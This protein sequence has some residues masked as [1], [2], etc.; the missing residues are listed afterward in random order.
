MMGGGI[1][2]IALG[3]QGPHPQSTLER[4][5][6][7]GPCPWSVARSNSL[8]PSASDGGLGVPTSPSPSAG[9]LGP[10]EQW[11]HGPEHRSIGRRQATPTQA[12]VAERRPRA[13]SRGEAAYPAW[14][15]PDLV[16]KPRRL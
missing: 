9:S 15:T 11:R 6:V 13:L 8:A 10:P 5:V 4:S 3:R 12:A 16:R 2:A 1:A 14:R 7:K